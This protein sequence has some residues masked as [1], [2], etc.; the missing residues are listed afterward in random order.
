VLDVAEVVFATLKRKLLSS[1]RIG[2]LNVRSYARGWFGGYRFPVHPG[3]PLSFHPR[4][5]IGG[6][7]INLGG[8]P[9]HSRSVFTSC[10]AF[11][12][13]NDWR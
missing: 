10:I 9:D 2:L 3:F 4:Q 5:I 7:I 13:L 8:G 6:L 11:V 1:L 12:L